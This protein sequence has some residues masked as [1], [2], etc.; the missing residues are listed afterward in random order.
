MNADDCCAVVETDPPG[1]VIVLFP[2]LPVSVA[3]VP[4]YAYQPPVA[5][6]VDTSA[7]EK[8]RKY[9]EDEVTG[10]ASLFDDDEAER[11]PK[12]GLAAETGRPLK[13]SSLRTGLRRAVRKA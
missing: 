2:K 9:I 13:P 3:G 7:R 6:S 5:T 1:V 12:I 8:V 10:R 4:L 11:R